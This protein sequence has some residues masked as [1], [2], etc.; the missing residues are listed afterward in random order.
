MAATL[1]AHLACAGTQREFVPIPIPEGRSVV[2]LYRASSILAGVCASFLLY[3]LFAKRP[4]GLIELFGAALV[5]GAILVLSL[6]SVL[7]KRRAKAAA[8]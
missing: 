1:A 3:L 6:P 8:G 4:P 5:I 7:K 2:Y